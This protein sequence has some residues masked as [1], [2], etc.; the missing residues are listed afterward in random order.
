MQSSM[1][2][3][4][5]QVEQKEFA[6]SQMLDAIIALYELVKAF[7]LR[8]VDPVDQNLFERWSYQCVGKKFTA[9]WE[10]HTRPTY[11]ARRKQIPSP[12]QPLRLMC[13]MMIHDAHICQQKVKC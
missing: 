4:S 7:C 13:M 2:F 3:R 10:L 5:N 6:V 8:A 11:N 1:L 12:T 9:W